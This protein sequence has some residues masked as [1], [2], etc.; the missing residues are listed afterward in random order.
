M[1]SGLLSVPEE[2]VALGVENLKEEV[3]S[4]KYALREAQSEI[5]KYKVAGIPAS[6]KMVCFCEEEL[7][8][9]LPRY[10]VNLVL[11]Q[12]GREFCAVLYGAEGSGCRYILGSKT[13]DLRPLA[14]ELNQ[15]FSGRGGGKAEMVQGFVQGKMDVIEAWL[16]EQV[17]E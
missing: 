5:L 15:V 13:M 14:K 3:T 8:G 4:W 16:K 7:D 2:N 1:I 12:E 17:K 9:D 11:L 10:L 6:Q